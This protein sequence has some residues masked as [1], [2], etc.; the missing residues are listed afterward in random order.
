MSLQ[1]YPYSICANWVLNM[2]Y[3][4]IADYKVMFHRPPVY[5]PCSLCISHVF[6]LNIRVILGKKTRSI[7]IL[8]L[9]NLTQRFKPNKVFHLVHNERRL[10]IDHL[11]FS[12]RETVHRAL[13]F[14]LIKPFCFLEASTLLLFKATCK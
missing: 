1:R 3:H 12:L 11:L 14:P 13:A 6:C 5:Q 4:V 7:R 9:M 10:L 2:Y 8:Y